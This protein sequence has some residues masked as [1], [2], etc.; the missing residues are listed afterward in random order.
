MS[1]SGSIDKLV[2][3]NEVIK[4]LTGIGLNRDEKL[5][6]AAAKQT[7]QHK[8]SNRELALDIYQYLW[9]RVLI[10]NSKI[11]RALEILTRAA[12]RY[13]YQSNNYLVAQVFYALQLSLLANN[14]AVN[15][16]LHSLESALAN[17]KLAIK[18]TKLPQPNS[19]V[20][21]YIN[22]DKFIVEPDLALL[23]VLTCDIAQWCLAIAAKQ[24]DELTDPQKIIAGIL[25]GKD[26][27]NQ[28][29]LHAHG[30]TLLVCA[31]D[32]GMVDATYLLAIEFMKNSNTAAQGLKLMQQAADVGH[33][34]AS[35]YLLKKTAASSVATEIKSTTASTAALAS[36]NK[37]V[38]NAG[39]ASASNSASVTATV[40]SNSSAATSSQ[41]ADSKMTTQTLTAR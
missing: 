35:R 17:F 20:R 40:S 27:I 30:L 29:A 23:V 21:K 32:N 16:K 28:N 13:S 3:I 6:E 37:A 22:T 5:D 31:S 9:A 14:D 18:E 15:T 38:V 1:T 7:L 41:T 36:S 39:S 10:Q 24:K 19:G 34:Q 2:T 4:Y 11:P 25:L 12:T 8:D 33:E 26:T